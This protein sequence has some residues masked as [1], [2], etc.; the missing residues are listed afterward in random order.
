MKISKFEIF[1]FLGINFRDFVVFKENH[2]FLVIVKTLGIAESRNCNHGKNICGLSHHF[3]EQ[4]MLLNFV[5]LYTIFRAML[6]IPFKF[7][8]SLFLKF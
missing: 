6:Q 8:F 5:D 4:L 1:K 7:N 2:K 3:T